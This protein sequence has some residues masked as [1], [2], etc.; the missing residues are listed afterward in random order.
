M[1]D[2]AAKPWSYWL[3]PPLLA[4]TIAFLVAWAV[5]YYR[6]GGGSA[7]PVDPV[8]TGP[9]AAGSVTTTARPEEGVQPHP[10]AA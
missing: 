6:R 4:T 1:A 2:R 9:P 8:A 7:L 3:A 5:A 10:L